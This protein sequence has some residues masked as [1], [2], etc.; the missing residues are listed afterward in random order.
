MQPDVGVLITLGIRRATN[1]PTGGV[2]TKVALGKHVIGLDTHGQE[3]PSVHAAPQVVGELVGRTERGEHGTAGIEGSLAPVAL[4]LVIVI[5]NLEDALRAPLPTLFPDGGIA[6]VQRIVGVGYDF[7]HIAEGL[8]IAGG[9]VL[10]HH[11]F[12]IEHIGKGLADTA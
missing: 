4:C 5:V 9:V 3:S 6:G 10:V 8:R 12:G 7:L 2:A 1:I 11:H